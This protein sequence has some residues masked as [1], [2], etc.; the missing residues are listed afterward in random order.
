MRRYGVG[1]KGEAILNDTHSITPPMVR[2][3]IRVSLCLRRL[4]ATTNDFTSR[5][6]MRKNLAYG[7]T[8]DPQA[9]P[10]TTD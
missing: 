3:V 4:M 6:Y 2:V 7:R 5:G 9:H 1:T 8:H 10:V